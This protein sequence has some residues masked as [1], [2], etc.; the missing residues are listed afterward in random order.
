[1]KK[2]IAQIIV[3]LILTM[4]SASL[5]ISF[6]FFSQNVTEDVKN[7]TKEEIEHGMTISDASFYID[8]FNKATGNFEI[9]NTGRVPL[10]VSLFKFYMNST[11]I[12]PSIG[13]CSGEIQPGDKCFVSLGALYD[14]SK[15]YI[16]KVTGEYDTVDEVRTWLL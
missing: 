11:L 12:S 5:A 16:I 13:G 1:M 8:N 7:A 9:K 2:G 6:L 15:D 10:K 4:I 14:P 3:V